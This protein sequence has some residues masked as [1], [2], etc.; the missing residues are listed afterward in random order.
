MARRSVRARVRLQDIFNL[1]QCLLLC[2]NYALVSLTQ[3][4]QALLIACLATL[5]QKFSQM[6]KLLLILQN[7]LRRQ[8]PSSKGMEVAQRQTS[9]IF[10]K[11]T[12]G[13]EN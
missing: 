1:A 7:G 9:H 8:M 12:N 5:H 10:V 6:S 2:I 3:R 4:R 13:I 11:Q